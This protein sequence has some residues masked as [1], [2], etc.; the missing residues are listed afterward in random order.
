MHDETLQAKIF[1]SAKKV[2]D[3]QL[4]T[5]KEMVAAV[6]H[7]NVLKDCPPVVGDNVTLKYD[8]QNDQYE[9]LEVRER[10]SEIFRTIVREQ[11]KKVIAS[12]VDCLVIVSSVSKPV[13]KSGLIDRYLLR[14]NQWEIPAVVVFNKMDE[15]DDQF[16]LEFERKKLD[17][18]LVKNFCVVAK[19]P[20]FGNFEL[21][22]LKSFLKGQ[23]A[24][25]VGQSGVGKSK[26]IT[27]LSGGKVELKSNRLAKGVGKGSHTTTWAEMIDCSDFYLI[28]SP[29]V[30]SMS[31]D[32]LDAE[33]LIDCFE[34]LHEGI[35]KCQF[36]DCK[37]GPKSRGCYFQELDS[38]VFENQVILERLQSYI[39]FRDEILDRKKY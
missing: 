12:N 2:F 15:F 27:S 37:H 23:T 14:A 1:K 4:A 10:E 33:E 31:I 5:S 24:M 13:Y 35:V 39:R 21:D 9:I 25:F 29:G 26:M 17:Y 19:N 7:G 6:A 8:Q 30:R 20:E 22:D 34:D 16:D 18:L 38:E 36:N 32:D 3:C 28:D 11:K